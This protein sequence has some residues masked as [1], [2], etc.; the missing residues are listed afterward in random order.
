VG[1]Q[2]HWLVALPVR[3]LAEIVVLLLLAAAVVSYQ[4]DLGDRW[5]GWGAADPATE[6]AAVQPPEG[7]K[8]PASGTARLVARSSATV[9]ADPGRVAAAVQP[10]LRK[11]VLGRHVG[12]L[13]TDLGSGRPLFRAG[14]TAVTPASTTKLLTSTAALSALGP[15]VRFRTTVRYV[16]ATRQLVLVG[17]GDPF[18]ASSP[19]MGVASY[20]DRADVVTLA[21]QTVRKLRSMKVR[22]VKL[23][24][25]DSYFSGP[26]VNPQWPATYIPEDVVPPI[27]SLWVDEGQ[28]PDGFGFV[29]DPAA[30]AAAAFRS[31]L[32]SAGMKVGPQ[33]RRMNTPTGA[34]EVASAASAPLGEIVERTLAVSD[35][36]AAEVLARQVGL[37][38]RQEGSFQAGAAAVLGVL[39]R[40][41]VPV[42]G[43]QL[44]DGSGLS[45]QDLLSTDTLAAVVRLAAS[46]DH[47]ELR[48]VLTG[49]PVAGFTGSLTY[50]FAEGPAAARGRVRAKTGT[51]TG[52]H[53]LAGVADDA[54]G[55]RMAFVVV[56]DRVRPL[57]ELEAQTLIDRIAGALGACRCGVGSRP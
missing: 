9:P 7:L 5:F 37:A 52:V 41:G 22:R 30:G 29:A 40:L 6:P 12:V 51:L 54:T 10:K 8:L 50:R 34:T 11:R 48:Q 26:S 57:K 55:A 16:P 44:Y 18:L 24:F 13:V 27:S 35:N 17:G 14:A 32:T 2:R 53:G 3:F 23:G 38:E 46:R 43:A 31:A 36:Q 19:K 49:L 1:E 56:A 4:Y 28:D 42:E 45:R 21:T 20:P 33:V 39:R 25:D 47:P 15:M